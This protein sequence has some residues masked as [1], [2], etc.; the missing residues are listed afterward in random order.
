MSL[1]G[2]YRCTLFPRNTR[3]NMRRKKRNKTKQKTREKIPF[4]LRNR[5]WHFCSTPLPV[6]NFRT[7]P[8][9]AAENEFHVAGSVHRPR[10]SIS[11]RQAARKAAREMY[12]KAHPWDFN[13]YLFANKHCLFPSPRELFVVDDNRT[14]ERSAFFSRSHAKSSKS[15]LA[16]SH[17]TYVRTYRNFYLVQRTT[18]ILCVNIIY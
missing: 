5:D 1:D 14:D 3:R 13:F 11:R 16:P 10:R 17:I 4:S 8:P 7:S 15:A 9:G 18:Y 12:E 2:K 6:V